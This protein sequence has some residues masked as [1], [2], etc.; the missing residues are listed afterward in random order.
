M[1]IPTK[2]RLGAVLLTL[3]MVLSLLPMGAVA[4]GQYSVTI[5]T[6]EHGSILP[7]PSSAN[8]NDTV[9]LT[10]TPDE[11]YTISGNPIVTYPYYVGDEKYYGI[12]EVTAVSANKYTFTM[13]AADVSVTATFREQTPWERFQQQF[14]GTGQISLT[15]AVTMETGMTVLSGK[16][17]VLDLNGKTLDGG[18]LNQCFTVED[19]GSLTVKDSANGGA[20]KGSVVVEHGG[21]FTMNGG[22]ISGA[23][24]QYAVTADGSFTITGGTISNNSNGGVFVGPKGSFSV[25]GL[26]NISGN[27]VLESSVSVSHNVFLSN[28]KTITVSNT[29]DGSSRIGV[30][31]ATDPAADN[32]VVITSGLSQFGS[33]GVF[34]SDNQYS[35]T[36]ANGEAVLTAQPPALHAPGFDGHALV[37]SSQ[38]GVKFKVKYPA[39]YDMSGVSVDFSVADGRTSSMTYANAEKITGEQACYFICYINAME[40]A[41]KITATLNFGDDTDKDEYSA[42]DYINYVQQNMSDNAKLLKLVNALQDYGYYMQNQT[43]WTEVVPHTHTAI[44][45]PSQSLPGDYLTAAEAGVSEMAAEKSLEGAGIVETTLSL[46]LNESTV[47]RVSVRPDT[48]VSVTSTDCEKR[49]VAGQVFYRFTTEKIGAASLGD[50][51]LITAETNQGTGSVR[52][53]AMSYVYAVLNNDALPENTKLAM[54]AY[55][56]YYQAAKNYV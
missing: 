6:L 34:S 40:L 9:T 51:R 4:A 3:A 45:G 56:Y 16:S 7:E 49:T 20:L 32:P 11:G 43:Q 31:T 44:S 1:R 48:N 28:T 10:V 22:T 33:A 19:G 47:L 17:V 39:N 37:L 36:T 25:S 46:A 53:S 21:S 55:Y 12:R 35:V 54:A 50:P 15:E 18:S 23:S 24:A 42:M 13:P 30:T 2:R 27:A 29:L 8:W 38:I 52:A 26:V 5:A 14:N 41:D